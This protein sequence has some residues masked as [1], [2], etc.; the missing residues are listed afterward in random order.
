M[1]TKFISMPQGKKAINLSAVYNRFGNIVVT[2]DEVD[3]FPHVSSSRFRIGETV[4]LTNLGLIYSTYTNAFIAMGFKNTNY[5]PVPKTLRKGEIFSMRCHEYDNNILLGITLEDGSQCLI[6]EDGVTK[7]IDI[8]L[9][10]K[11]PC[12]VLY[13]PYNEI[14]GNDK[15]LVWELQY[16][17]GNGYMAVDPQSKEKFLYSKYGVIVPYDTFDF[18]EPNSPQNFE[19]SVI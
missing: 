19:K 8:K 18:N 9:G 17:M 5:N 12:M 15:P 13:R 10:E 14:N 1:E 16:Y 11:T 4:I 2:Y 3:S 7:Y 6:D